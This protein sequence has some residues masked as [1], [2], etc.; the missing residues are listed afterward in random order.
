MHASFTLVFTCESSPVKA[1]WLSQAHPQ[2]EYIF[3]DTA[4]LCPRQG[5]PGQLVHLGVP[6][7]RGAGLPLLAEVVPF[8]GRVQLRTACADCMAL[9]ESDP[10]SGGHRYEET[11]LRDFFGVFVSNITS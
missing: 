3:R 11:P 7:L 2:V 9:F 1:E 4:E 8:E 10:A 6:P 5:V